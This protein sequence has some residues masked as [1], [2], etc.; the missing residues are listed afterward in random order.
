MRP[1]A[2]RGRGSSSSMK[3]SFP[4]WGSGSVE[5]QSSTC[6]MTWHATAARV[7][8]T[9]RSRAPKPRQFFLIDPRAW[10]RGRARP[11]GDADHPS[12]FSVKPYDGAWGRFV[13]LTTRTR[14]CS[15]QRRLPCGRHAVPWTCRRGS[16]RASLTRLQ[17]E[18]PWETPTRGRLRYRDRQIQK[19]RASM[20]TLRRAG[21]PRKGGSPRA[22]GCLAASASIYLATEEGH[23]HGHASVTPEEVALGIGE[24]VSGVGTAYTTSGFVAPKAIPKPRSR[25]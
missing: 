10:K 23:L 2:H 7:E 25:T 17:I 1:A 13:A 4:I 3:L 14:P 16:K 18:R 11:R 12:P 22:L 21:G 19:W 9:R 20:G 24:Q 5:W 15:G 6:A 8:S